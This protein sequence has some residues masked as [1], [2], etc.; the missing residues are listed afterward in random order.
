MNLSILYMDVVSYISLLC[1]FIVVFVMAFLFYIVI[2]TKGV[3][4]MDS[5]SSMLE[6]VWTIVPTFGVLFLCIFNVNFVLSNIEGEVD[7][8]SK[9][10]GRQWYWSYENQNGCYDSYM[11]SLINNVDNPLVLSYGKTN[12]LL[13]TSSDVIH[14]FSVPSLGLKADAI[15]GRIN[16]IITIPDRVGIFVG[17][18]SELCGVNHSYMPIVVEVINS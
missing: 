8:T 15:P 1:I 13:I 11:L 12:R 7:D 5:E 6:L 4:A 9:I 14:S 16:Q 18:C 3:M 2:F 17:Y 10:I